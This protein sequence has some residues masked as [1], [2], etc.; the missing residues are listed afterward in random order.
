MKREKGGITEH[1]KHAPQRNQGNR[2]EG[3]RYGRMGVLKES[4]DYKTGEQR[5]ER[6]GFSWN[7]GALVYYIWCE[8]FG[9]P[10]S[11]FCPCSDPSNRQ[12]Q[13]SL[14]VF[15]SRCDMRKGSLYQ[16]MFKGGGARNEACK[17]RRGLGVPSRCLA[18]SEWTAMGLSQTG[19]MSLCANLWTCPYNHGGRYLRATAGR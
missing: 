17:L 2:K 15:H 14:L 16:D 9:C 1:Y 11:W 18:V 8:E 7:S 19:G 12:S 10:T 6:E 4:G 3:K 5:E 13:D